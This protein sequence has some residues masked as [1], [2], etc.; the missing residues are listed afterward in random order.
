MNSKVNEDLP[1]DCGIV[2]DEDGFYK[3]LDYLCRAK[4]GKLTLHSLYH[5]L[6]C[7]FGTFCLH[8]LLQRGVSK[9]IAVLSANMSHRHYCV[10]QLR[11]LWSLMMTHLQL[12]EEQLLSLIENSMQRMMKVCIEMI[13]ICIIS[14]FQ[15]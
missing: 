4:K 12:T 2:L 6:W 10:S 7:N 11:K 3:K 14:L 13:T 9:K 1:Y 15:Y 5:L 8:L